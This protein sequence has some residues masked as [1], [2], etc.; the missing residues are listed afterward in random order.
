MSFLTSLQTDWN[1]INFTVQ[2]NR[3]RFRYDSLTRNEFGIEEKWLIC[4]RVDEK[5]LLSAEFDK[6]MRHDLCAVLLVAIIDTNT[7][8]ARTHIHSVEYR[9]L[10]VWIDGEQKMNK[11][12]SNL[13][14]AREF[15]VCLT[16]PRVCVCNVYV[17]SVSTQKSCR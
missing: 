4:Q 2:P 16:L 1:F 7:C 10:I 12:H 3:M 11:I 17:Y 5:R 14:Y 6:K 8:T 15:C 13:A 9:T